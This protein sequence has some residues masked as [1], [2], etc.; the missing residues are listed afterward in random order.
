DPTAVRCTAHS[1]IPPDH[2]PS[3]REGPDMTR[4]DAP[5]DFAS[6]HVGPREQDVAAMLGQ[7]GYASIKDVV[8]DTVPASI[9]RDEPLALPAALAEPAL[10]AKLRGIAGKNRVFRSYLGLGYA[11]THTPGVIQRNI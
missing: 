1:A 7:L 11:D 6:R 9:R 2:P 5:A 4:I 8:R 3:S 10:L